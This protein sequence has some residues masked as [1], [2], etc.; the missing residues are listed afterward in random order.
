[1]TK[2]KQKET[3]AELA[4]LLGVDEQAILSHCRQKSLVDAR[5]IIV[6]FMSIYRGMRQIDI[7]E[8]LEISQPA[9]CKLHKHHCS[10]I[11]SC[12]NY[13]NQWQAIQKSL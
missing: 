4:A 2:Q 12:V 11:K 9:V 13:F 3:L 1:M 6:A 5:A 8:M 10:K 7:A